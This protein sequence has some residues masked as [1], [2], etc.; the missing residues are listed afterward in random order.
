MFAFSDLS[1]DCLRLPCLVE[2]AGIGLWMFGITLGYKFL[3]L[4][5]K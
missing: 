4:C 2:W 3:A 5:K 1:E